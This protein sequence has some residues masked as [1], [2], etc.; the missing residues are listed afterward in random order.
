MAGS[1]RSEIDTQD[2]KPQPTMK[3][4]YKAHPVTERP[5]SVNLPILLTLRMLAAFGLE[6]AGC[7]STIK[8]RMISR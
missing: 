1:R 3:A 2:T 4:S 8:A 6:V 5:K 7:L